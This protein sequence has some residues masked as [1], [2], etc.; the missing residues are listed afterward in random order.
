MSETIPPP[1]QKTTFPFFSI[2]TSLDKIDYASFH[3]RKQ[4]TTQHLQIHC[5]TRQSQSSWCEF[6]IADDRSPSY[7]NLINN[8]KIFQTNVLYFF[9]LLILPFPQTRTQIPFINGESHHSICKNYDLILHVMP[10]SVE[11]VIPPSDYLK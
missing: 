4:Y 7:N 5:S 1:P 2:R 8:C 10:F 11:I 9:S 6:I 3:Q